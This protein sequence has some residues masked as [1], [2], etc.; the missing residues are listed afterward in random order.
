MPSVPPTQSVD[1]PVFS[2]N[3]GDVTM[4][5]VRIM[6]CLSTTVDLGIYLSVDMNSWHVRYIWNYLPQSSETTIENTKGTVIRPI[7]SSGDLSK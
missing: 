3:F 6:F 5:L 7:P 1:P 2:V 4:L